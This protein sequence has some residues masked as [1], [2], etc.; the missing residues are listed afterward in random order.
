M[1]LS[2]N[3]LG[4]ALFALTAVNSALILYLMVRQS[5]QQTLQQHLA[6]ET[7]TRVG[8]VA[9]E[10]AS[11]I[12][13]CATHLQERTL[14]ALEEIRTGL[15][16]HASAAEENHNKLA[17]TLITVAGENRGHNESLQGQLLQAVKESRTHTHAEFDQLQEAMASQRARLEADLAE[18]GRTQRKEAE[19]LG[20]QAQQL[21]GQ[22]RLVAHQAQLALVEQ[23]T[24]LVQS[25]KITNAVDLTHALV[26]GRELK[27]ETEEFVKQ[28]GECKVT[29]MED[30]L[31]GQV[32]EI[33]Y[34]EGRKVSS[35]TFENGQLKY[36]ISFDEQGRATKGEEFNQKGELA[37]EYHYDLAGEVASR[38][39]HSGAQH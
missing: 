23:L 36:Q 29:A 20:S 31:S 21:A 14:T 32:T 4:L 6:K 25:L 1:E 30:K 24:G 34:Q 26:E 22:Q 18:V 15:A 38:H 35:R 39:D 12:T 13:K 17:Q 19:A 11:L 37:F 33:L 8:D 7:E 3:D 28:L 16:R 2:L 10:L 9:T 27:V 5:A